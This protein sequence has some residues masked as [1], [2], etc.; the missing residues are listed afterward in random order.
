MRYSTGLLNIA[1]LVLPFLD[2]ANGQQCT[3]G[4]LQCTDPYYGGG[5]EQCSNG[6]WF[7][8]TCGSTNICYPFQGVSS[9]ENAS[10]CFLLHAT[11]LPH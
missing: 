8:N 9:I 5:W 2:L 11:C 1:V 3:S 6:V 10:V 4:A 7:Q